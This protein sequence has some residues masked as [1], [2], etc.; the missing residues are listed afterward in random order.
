MHRYLSLLLLLPLIALAANPNLIM[1]NNEPAPTTALTPRAY[2]PLVTTGTQTTPPPDQPPPDQPPPVQRASFFV[3]SSWKTSGAAVEVDNQKAIHMAYHYYE[4]QYGGDQ[5][6]PTYAVYRY[7]AANCNQGANW[8][9]VKL[10]ED[11]GVRVN[12]VQ[13]AVTPDGRPRLLLRTWRNNIY[14]N[15]D[16]YYAQCDTNCIDRAQWQ[17]TYLIPVA[18]VSPMNLTDNDLPQRYFDVDNQGNPAFVYADANYIAEPDRYGTYYVYCQ[19]DCGNIDNWY[20]V[21][22]GEHVYGTAN[23]ENFQYPS[24]EFTSN[25]QPRVLA[26]FTAL[27]GDTPM[28]HYLACD[29]GCDTVDGWKRVALWPRG[30]GPRPGWDLEL[31]ANDNPRVL[32]YPEA[33]DNGT[34]SELYYGW[35]NINCVNPTNWGKTSLGLGAYHGAAP[36]L[37]IDAQGRSHAIFITQ[38]SGIGYA[39]CNANC[40]SSQATWQR[41]DIDTQATLAQEWPVAFAPVCTGGI[42]SAWT[43]AMAIDSTGG[44]RMAFDAA[45]HANCWWS[46]DQW[47]SYYQMYLVQRSVRGVLIQ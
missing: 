35:C 16:Y 38:N 4:A 8:H 21:Q 12:E 17:V 43:P 40:A 26:A 27:S 29:T 22:I 42:W 10:L 39:R 24:L 25:G 32:Y 11:L 33:L 37:E 41:Q 6:T 13:L 1:A 36:D 18:A 20:E 2:L 47:Q 28:L 7:C 14:V 31:D 44:L 19:M 9:E 46:Q 23:A 3:D 45:Y 15:Y 30:Q 5:R 34:G